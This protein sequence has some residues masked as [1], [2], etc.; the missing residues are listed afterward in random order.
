[1]SLFAFLIAIAT[2]TYVVTES[3]A[4]N[5]TRIPLHLR[6]VILVLVLNSTNLGYTSVHNT[7]CSS[8]VIPEVSS[9]FNQ[10]T[11]MI[12]VKVNEI[13]IDKK[14]NASDNK[15]VLMDRNEASLKDLLMMNVD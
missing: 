3:V 10:S 4:L 11:R 15:E 6:A 14:K 8:Q 2:G 13:K 12:P 5:F 7:K 1:M 9:D